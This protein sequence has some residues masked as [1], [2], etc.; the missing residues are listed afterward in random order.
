MNKILLSAFLLIGILQGC[1]QSDEFDQPKKI[2][3]IGTSITEGCTYVENA[4]KANGY[5]VY[6]KAI[7]SSGICLNTGILGNGRDG[8]DLSET[9]QEKELRYNP[10]VDS[11]TME[12]YKNY[13]WERV[14]KPYLDGTIDKVDAIWFDHG[15]NDR[16]QIY[17]ELKNLDIVNWDIS[18]TS[19][20]S[21]FS[22]AFK[23]LLYQI[24]KLKPDIKIVIS[25]NL[26]GESDITVRGGAGIKLM[27][28]AIAKAYGFTLLRTW[29]YTGFNFQYVPNSSNYISEFNKTYGTSY[30]PEWT[31]CKGNITYYQLYNPDTVHPFTDLTGKANNKLDSIFTIMWKDLL[32]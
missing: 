17:S 25:G 8:K 1:T 23:Y 3:A 27:Q 19:D 31:D 28:E 24:F 5:M 30:T 21:K 10:Y 9:I 18:E 20:R 12:K 26:E 2:L 6:N 22:G 11:I 15:F 4:S 32:Y 29:E 7:G 13:S 16:Y 14:I